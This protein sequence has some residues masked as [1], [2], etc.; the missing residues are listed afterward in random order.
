LSPLFCWKE[1]II[2]EDNIKVVGVYLWV[3]TEDQAKEEL[4][5][6]VDFYNESIKDLQDKVKTC[7]V[8]KDNNKR[9]KSEINKLNKKIKNILDN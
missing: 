1:G 4:S 8:I 5:L 7:E 3:S 6:L 2:Q 9:M